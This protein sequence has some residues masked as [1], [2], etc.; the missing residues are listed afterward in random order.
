M[1]TGTRR[2]LIHELYLTL[3]FAVLL[4]L[5]IASGENAKGWDRLSCVLLALGTA[6]V[7]IVASSIYMIRIIIRER[8]RRPSWPAMGVLAIVVL[9]AGLFALWIES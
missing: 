6:V 9:L 2:Y 1:L 4:V 8:A 3:G 7:W 5:L